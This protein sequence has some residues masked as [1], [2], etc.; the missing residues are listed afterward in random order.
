MLVLGQF[1]RGVI[2]GADV[3]IIGSSHAAESTVIPASAY[4]STSPRSHCIRIKSSLAPLIPYARHTGN[5]NKTRLR[6]TNRSTEYWSV[7]PCHH[8]TLLEV[9]HGRRVH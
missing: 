1:D 6:W 3:Q 5:L 4:K 7:D 2:E 9:G 8:D